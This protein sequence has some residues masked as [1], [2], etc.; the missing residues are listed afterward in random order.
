MTGMVC[1]VAFRAPLRIHP[2]HRLRGRWMVLLGALV[3]LLL[4][5]AG[6]GITPFFEF[7]VVFDA[8]LRFFG[9]RVQGRSLDRV[10]ARFAAVPARLAVLRRVGR[11][12]GCRGAEWAGGR[13]GEARG[14]G[15]QGEEGAAGAGDGEARHVVVVVE[16]TLA[17]C[18]SAVR[19]S[20]RW[21]RSL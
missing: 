8:L 1:S 4:V 3:A 21:Y 10:V 6:D 12:A 19:W 15:A 5:P 7:L 18:F 2:N 16:W 9:L 14:R 11:E 13:G 20:S 17:L